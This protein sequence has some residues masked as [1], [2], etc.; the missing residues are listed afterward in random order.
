[1]PY[2]KKENCYIVQRVSYIVLKFS[3]TPAIASCTKTEIEVS[4][5]I[6]MD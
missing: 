2:I 3:V 6:K 5:E 4:Q 1:M